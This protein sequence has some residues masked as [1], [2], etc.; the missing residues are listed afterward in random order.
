M[1]IEIVDSITKVA[2]KIPSKG[3][4]SLDS[5][6]KSNNTIISSAEG[7]PTIIHVYLKYVSSL[8]CISSVRFGVGSISLGSK[9]RDVIDTVSYNQKYSNTLLSLVSILWYRSPYETSLFLLFSDLL[10]KVYLLSTLS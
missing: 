2:T 1:S 8:Y 3:A 6:L 9:L 4:T 5:S 7:F 10:N